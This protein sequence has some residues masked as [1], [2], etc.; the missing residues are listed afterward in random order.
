MAAHA[1]VS[2]FGATFK[3]PCTR[4]F[5]NSSRRAPPDQLVS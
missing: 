3:S 1:D 5:R 4:A 2:H